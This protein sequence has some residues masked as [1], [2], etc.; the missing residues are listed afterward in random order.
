[1]T[2]NYK[3]DNLQYNPDFYG[4]EELCCC[5]GLKINRKCT[6]HGEKLR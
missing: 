4:R 5:T 1:M 6:I 2:D 3:N